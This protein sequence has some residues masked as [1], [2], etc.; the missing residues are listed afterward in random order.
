M[1]CEELEK[2][3]KLLDALAHPLRLCMVALLWKHGSMYLAEIAEHLGVSRALAK[4]HLKK[5]ESAG[6]VE[7]SVVVEEGKAIAKRYYRLKWHGTLCLSP[8]LI[9]SIIETCGG[10]HGERCRMG[11]GGEER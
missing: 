4:I 9:A 1:S 8:E 10:T 5:L 6:I 3:A 7:S 11:E 2:I